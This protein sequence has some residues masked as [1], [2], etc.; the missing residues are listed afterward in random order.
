VPVA[1]PPVPDAKHAVSGF[2]EGGG[3]PGATAAVALRRLGTRVRFYSPLTD[4]EPGRRQRRELEDAGVDLAACPVLAGHASPRAVILVEEGTGRRTIFWSRGDLPA[5]DPDAVP[6]GLLDG[7]DLLYSDGHDA[8]CAAALAREA[9]ARGLPV[10][11]DAGSV[12]EGSAEL[13][14]VCT[15]VISSRDFAPDLTGRRDPAAA[16]AALRD[17]GPGRVGL[18]W[19]E[20][21]VLGLDEAG[22][23][24]VPAFAVGV[25]DTTGAGDAFHAG[26]AHALLEG[27]PFRGCLEYGAAVAALKCRRHGGRPGLPTRPE[28][29]ALLAAG[30]RRPPGPLARW[31]PDG[32]P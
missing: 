29:E 7:V 9:R 26:Y 4:D 27:R 32:P 25:R 5:L 8:P 15:D 20:H 24:V 3:G 12:R 17:L 16:L 21:G 6:P 10:V 23:H 22:L 30:P 11:M 18:T 2:H 19:G 14:R 1:G 31:L 28:V 13:V